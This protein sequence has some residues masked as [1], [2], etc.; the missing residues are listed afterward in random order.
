VLEDIAA[1]S[2]VAGKSIPYEFGPRRTSDVAE[3]YVDAS[4]ANELLG[5]TTKYDQARICQ[6][7]WR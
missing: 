7:S 3:N 5:W 1:F 2:E 6:D 4:L